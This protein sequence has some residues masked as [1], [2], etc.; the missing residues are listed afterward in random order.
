MKKDFEP[1]PLIHDIKPKLPYLV[2]ISGALAPM[3]VAGGLAF[4]SFNTQPHTE[5]TRTSI[6]RM[7]PEKSLT[8]A[9]IREN[10][11]LIDQE[12]RKVVAIARVTE[13]QMADE[14]QRFLSAY[15][16]PRD[17]KRPFVVN[18]TTFPEAVRRYW[19]VVDRM[20]QSPNPELKKAG[21]KLLGFKNSGI[22]Q[23]NFG[24]S[25]DGGHALMRSG[26]GI[27]EGKLYLDVSISADA[28]LNIVD[29]TTLSLTLVHETDHLDRM[30]QFQESLPASLSIQERYQKE[31]E[32]LGDKEKIVKEEALAFAAGARAFI[33]QSGLGFQ[34]ETS[35]QHEAA[36]FIRAGQNAE[37]PRWIRFVENSISSRG[38]LDEYDLTPIPSFP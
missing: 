2:T 36:E 11:R 34:S 3:V 24:P 1:R 30:F 19:T 20:T 25:I 38:Q 8:S 14:A 21:Q 17:N 22:T 5:P 35:L 18:E 12:G 31:Q 9:E 37:N 29:P 6:T 4:H 23:F 10:Q 27:N 26:V 33:F 16:D 7:R 15:P 28:I 32:R 13:R